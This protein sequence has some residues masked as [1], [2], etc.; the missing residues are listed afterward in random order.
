[1][2]TTTILNCTDYNKMDMEIYSISVNIKNFDI[3][4]NETTNFDIFF[5]YGHET[6]PQFNFKKF[7]KNINPSNIVE[8]IL[9]N[10]IIVSAV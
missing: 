2:V 4:M 9:E 8:I 3:S 10:V 5:T 7:D 6:N 1:M